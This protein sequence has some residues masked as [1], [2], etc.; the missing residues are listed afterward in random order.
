[1]RR[2]IRAI[3][4]ILPYLFVYMDCTSFVITTDGTKEEENL[5]LKDTSSKS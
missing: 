4:F 5:L 2:H 1:M 3:N